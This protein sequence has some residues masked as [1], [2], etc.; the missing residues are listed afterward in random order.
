VKRRLLLVEDNP[1]DQYLVIRALRDFAALEIEVASDGQEAYDYLFVERL[2]QPDLILLDLKMPRMSGLELLRSIRETPDT[3]SIPIVVFSSSD[4]P[5]EVAQ[6]TK[7]KA[8]YIQK[9]V[10]FDQHTKTLKDLITRLLNP[11]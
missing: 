4:E 11:S 1:D 6:V 8:E 5:A 3:S 2:P 10:D 9:P 7:L